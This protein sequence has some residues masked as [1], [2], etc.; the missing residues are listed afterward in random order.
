MNAEITIELKAGTHEVKFNGITGINAIEALTIVLNGLISNCTWKDALFFVYRRII[1]Y[2]INL[3]KKKPMAKKI[4]ITFKEPAIKLPKHLE[5]KSDM[6]LQ[7]EGIDGLNAIQ[8]LSGVLNGL[9]AEYV[10]AVNQ[11]VNVVPGN[12]RNLKSI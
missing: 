6:Q 7:I 11:A 12:E 9:I 10:G 2:L 3:I 8:I 1:I 4:T 5:G